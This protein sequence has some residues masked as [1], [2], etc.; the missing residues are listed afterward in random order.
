MDLDAHFADFTAR[1][2]QTIDEARV[3]F[4]VVGLE[5]FARRNV[6]SAIADAEPAERSESGADATETGGEEDADTDPTSRTN[7]C[8]VTVL[9]SGWPTWR[10]SK[11]STSRRRQDGRWRW[12]ISSDAAVAVRISIPTLKKHI[13]MF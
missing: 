7:F 10:R 6:L 4:A 2:W 11:L 5:G 1:D 3:R 9:V 12:A 8:E 13:N